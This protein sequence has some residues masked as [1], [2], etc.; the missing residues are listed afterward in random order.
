[1][2]KASHLV[3]PCAALALIS[4]SPAEGDPN[5]FTTA[6][7]I[8]TGVSTTLETG[9]GSGDGDGDGDSGDG[10][11]DGDPGDGDGDGDGVKLDVLPADTGVDDG[12][13]DESCDFVDLL[14]VIDNSVSMGGYQAAL[15]LAFPQFADT[16]AAVLPE[17]TNVHVGVTSSEMGYAGSGSTMISN[18]MC[19]FTGD[20]MPSDNF[21]I[22]PD[23]Q[24][25]GKNGAQGRLFDPGGGQHYFGFNVGDAAQTAALETW[26]SDAAAVGTGG[27]NIEMS[28]APAG[29]AFDPAN[30]ATNAGFVR[31]EGAVLV[32]FF[33]TDEP[34]QT[35]LMINGMSGG[36]AMLDKVAAA[37]SGCGGLDCVI[38]GGFLLES[39]C[40]AQGNLPLD[41][42]LEGMSEPPQVAPLPDDNLPAMQ[43]ADEMNALLADTLADAIAAKCDEI[44]PVG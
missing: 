35:P 5:P 8:D 44:P 26:F 1:M 33:M 6:A 43:A 28:T 13:G 14:F 11:G 27:S 36:Q 40:N 29:W 2:L 41:D 39:A 25:T 38:G 12:P 37:K 17:G 34:D 32:V 18:G 4:C 20:G 42:F 30:N 19:T 22:T 15:G 16:L 31:D 24:N 10:D 21:Y 9:T 7:S 23:M 3:I